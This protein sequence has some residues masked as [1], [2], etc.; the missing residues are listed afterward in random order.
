MKIDYALGNTS[1][2]L[3]EVT[4]AI[5]SYD[6]CVNS[7]AGGLALESVRQDAA[8][9]RKY[10]IEQAQAPAIADTESPEGQSPSQ[11]DSKQRGPNPRPRG[12][13]SGSDDQPDSSGPGGGANSGSD[14]Q[15]QRKHL[16]PRRRRMGGAGGT[17]NP[18]HADRG[19]TP[20]DRL[21]TA[22]EHIRESAQS[23]RLPEE[24]PPDSHSEGKDW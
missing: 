1:L 9:N 4:A 2:A 5:R 22:L 18:P 12:D 16:P 13:D 3:G 11:R 20:E 19:D 17:G 10:A 15:D 23:R 8:A 21:D 14:Q 6:D 24:V 7:T